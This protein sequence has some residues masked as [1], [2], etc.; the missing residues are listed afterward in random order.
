MV[1]SYSILIFPNEIF[2]WNKNSLKSMLFFI[3]LSI[4][5]VVMKIVKINMSGNTDLMISCRLNQHNI[6]MNYLTSRDFETKKKSLVWFSLFKKIKTWENWCSVK[7]HRMNFC[8]ILKYIPKHLKAFAQPIQ[9]KQVRLRKLPGFVLRSHS[10]QK[11]PL[12][13]VF[14]LDLLWTGKSEKPLYE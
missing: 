12:P 10:L 9:E 13:I 2:K 6:I 8:L 1:V 14:S 5:N 3:S 4:V 7:Q 11:I